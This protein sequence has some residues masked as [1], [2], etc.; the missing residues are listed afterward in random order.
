MSN[1]PNITAAS[2]DLIVLGR[3][4]GTHALR[5][6]V[7][8]RLFN[9]DS[10]ALDGAK[11]VT[12]RLPDGRMV[13][14]ALAHVRPHQ[15]ALLATFTGCHSI[16]DAESLVGAEVCVAAT[17]LPDLGPD[18]VYHFQLVGMRVSTTEGRDLGSVAEVMDLPAH[19]VCVVRG[20]GREFLIPFIDEIVRDVDI[21]ARHLVIEPMPGLLED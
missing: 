18:E 11:S 3:I 17:D 5:G 15:Q 4:A 13:Q 6:E 7:R 20:G 19:A 1:D 12:L 10:R 9:P 2:D 8:I 14:R 21:D 16:E